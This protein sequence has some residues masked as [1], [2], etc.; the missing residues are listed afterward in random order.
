MT[1]SK[2]SKRPKEQS[3]EYFR[4]PRTGRMHRRRSQASARPST[5][6]RPRSTGTEHSGDRAGPEERCRQR[7]YS[8]LF[9]SHLFSSFQATCACCPSKLLRPFH[10]GEYGLPICSGGVFLRH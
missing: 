3:P 10:Q 2:G 7:I 9:H 4:A 6:C 5:T 1:K 8:E